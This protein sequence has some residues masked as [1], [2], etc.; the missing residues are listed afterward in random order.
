MAAD[1]LD[2]AGFTV[3]ISLNSLLWTNIVTVENLLPLHKYARAS[4]E[5]ILEVLSFGQESSDKQLCDIEKINR[6][7]FRDVGYSYCNSN[8]VLNDLSFVAQSGRITTITGYSGCGKSTVLNIL[9]GFNIIQSGGILFNDTKVNSADLIGL[10]RRMG[11]IGQDT[12]LFNR[13]IRENL[14]YYVDE[15]DDNLNRMYDYL[16]KLD[17]KKLIE[18]QAEGVNTIID[19]GSSNISGGEK[20][21]LCLIRELMK[22]PEILILDEFTSHLDQSEET[23]IF[24]FI[25]EYLKDVVIIQVAHRQ[26]AISRGDMIYVID[27]GKVVERGTHAALLADSKFYQKLLSSI[28]N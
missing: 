1:K 5:R 7:E 11:Y 26:S 3:L 14:L 15:T 2:V 20:Q 22:N 24:S 27:D 16:E 8:C 6:I 13:S 21:R 28:V 9:L 25:K 19:D 17:L 4:C 12:F 23:K 10:R 18:S